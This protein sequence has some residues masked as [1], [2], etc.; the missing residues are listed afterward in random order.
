MI[1]VVVEPL[2][3][4]LVLFMVLWICFKLYYLIELFFEIEI[5]DLS[6]F[7]LKNVITK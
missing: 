5:D 6:Y 4:K 7:Y 2:F 3:V 1:G